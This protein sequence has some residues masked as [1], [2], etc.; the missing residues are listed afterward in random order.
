DGRG[1]AGS[2]AL[3]QGSEKPAGEVALGVR[4]AVRP[5][6][7]PGSLVLRPVAA[8]AAPPRGAT[9]RR[10]GHVASCTAWCRP[11]YPDDVDD[12]NVAAVCGLHGLVSAV[13]PDLV[14]RLPERQPP[15]ELERL[16][17]RQRVERPA[18]HVAVRSLQ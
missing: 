5:P 16:L 6:G 17:R 13:L 2:A 4:F 11:S 12:A 8:S 7:V 18:P 14:D 9:R 15:G 1:S 3:Q 10:G